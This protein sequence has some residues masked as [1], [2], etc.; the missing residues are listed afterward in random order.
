MKAD[1]FEILSFL[2][3]EFKQ[4]KIKKIRKYFSMDRHRHLV[5]TLESKKKNF[6]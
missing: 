3:I 5:E 6:I 2:L 4:N 1:I